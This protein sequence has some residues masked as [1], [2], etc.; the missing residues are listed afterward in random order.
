M[1]HLLSWIR[2]L[3]AIFF[4]LAL[5]GYLGFLL[6]DLYRSRSEIQDAARAQI[7]QD[8]DKRAL[9]IGYFFSERSDD[10]L[11]LS[12]N[13]EL[14]AYFENIALGMSM[15]YGLAASLDEA[16]TDLKKYRSRRKMGRWDIYQRVVFLDASGQVLIDAHAGTILP[17]KGEER[18]W[19]P[20]LSRNQSSAKFHT[21]VNGS[22]KIILITYP[23]F[24]KG[25]YSGHLL[26]WV[27]PSII[28][29]HFIADNVTDDNQVVVSLASQD[30]YLY[31]P[32][33]QF[34]PDQLPPLKS[35][36]KPEPYL[37]TVPF[38]GNAQHALEMLAVQTP[39]GTTPFS[40]VTIIPAK[41][42]KQTSPQ[43]LLLTTS[44]IGLL[45][46]IG[47]L[48]LIRS[49]ARNSLLGV[50]LEEINLREK[51]IAE[52]NIQLQ[53]A[54][55]AAEAANTA[56]SQFLANM[57]HE[58]R[59]PM[60][61][62]IGMAYLLEDTNLDDEQREYVELIKS[63]GS[64]LIEL[65]SNILDLSKIEA[66]KIELDSS[67][68]DLQTEISDIIKIHSPRAKSKGLELGSQ[69]DADVPLRL[70]GDTGR[71]RQIISN[72]LGN[73]L[74][75]SDK[76]TIALH[77]SKVTE[78]DQQT[79]LRFLVRDS[80]I[81]IAADKFGEIF[82]PFIQGDNS[83]SRKFG[84]T[85]LG[86]TIAR[87]LATMMGGTTGVESVV[88]EGATFWF[89]AVLEK[90]TKVEATA[91]DFSVSIDRSKLPLTKISTV[92]RILLAEDDPTNQLVTKSI[93]VKYGYTVDVANNG[94]EALKLL[95]VHDYS[96]V[97]MDCMMPVM[98]GYE[99]ITVIRDQASAVRNHAVPVIALT[100]NALKE[101]RNRCLA[102]GMNDFLSKPFTISQFSKMLQRW[103]P[104]QR[105][106]SPEDSPNMIDCA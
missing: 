62:L 14:S 61:G 37:F 54:K 25:Q 74:K 45:I 36:K 72:L 94:C 40:L 13:S 3:A 20:F 57:S 78:D 80:G 79:I 1:Q 15:E 29:Q 105:A 18:D 50:R 65:I 51:D 35:L 44:A 89:T 48:L 4:S 26:A 22:E 47:S 93:L 63:S 38:S 2:R 85:G 81:G 24:F 33:T 66:Q 90:Q 19:K 11:A 75:F 6:T 70:K 12:E 28:Y 100:A 91:L 21:L 30:E 31:S 83:T 92:T 58:I 84:G 67:D 5:V 73:A 17:R 68:F 41:A 86:L 56:K 49:N 77:I 59:T 106:T 60:N 39:I 16:K 69:I 9:A 95:G 46:L 27:S 97:L 99:A 32:A 96:L 8:T 7:L 71:L 34:P 102:A 103:L 87:Q 98:D 53:V 88:G 43:L 10:L 104:C 55:E 82:E 64:N 101:N 52:R 42:S 76:G 23:Y